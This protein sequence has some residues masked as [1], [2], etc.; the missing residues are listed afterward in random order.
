[1][2]TRHTLKLALF[3]VALSA[4]GIVAADAQAKSSYVGRLPSAGGEPCAICHLSAGGG[5]DKNAF[6]NLAIGG[7]PEWPTRPAFDADSDNDGYTNGQELGDP[8]GMWSTGMTSTTYLSNPGVQADTPCG[9]G[10][11]DPKGAGMEACDG[12]DLGGKTCADFGGTAEQALSCN[13]SCEF[14]TSA[15][16]APVD[17]ATPDMYPE[18]DETQDM[19]PEEDETPDDTTT[20]D[21]TPD[22]TDGGDASADM[23]GTEED[24]SEDEDDDTPTPEEDGCAQTSTGGPAPTGVLAVVLGM[25]GMFG[26]RRRRA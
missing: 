15:C 25:L 24:E 26:L 9:N 7:G 5:G 18:E 1:M 12:A 8:N 21:E 11:I 14:D 16:S 22:V 3:T 4:S 13:T 23:P 17:D 19:D 2:H 6:G 10:Q 20:E